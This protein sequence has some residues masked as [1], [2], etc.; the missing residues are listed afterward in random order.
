MNRKAL[1]KGLGALIP[2]A[3]PS[4]ATASAGQAPS[5]LPIERISSN[6]YQPRHQFDDAK[7]EELAQSIRSN[8]V[9]QPIVVRRSPDGDG[10]QL[11]AGERRFLAAKKAGRETIPAVVRAAS[12]REM[13]EFALVENVQREDLNPIDEAQAYHR[14]SLEFDFT[15][16]QM[17]ERVGK[18]RTTITNTLR[19]LNLSDPVQELI[20]GGRL[21]TGHAR[22]LLALE[23]AV[24]QEALAQE[25][26][27]R[28]LSVRQVEEMTAARRQRRPRNPA[29]RGRI[30]PLLASWEDELRHAFGTQVRIQGGT[31]RGR[32]EISYFSEEDLE[33]ILEVVGVISGGGGAAEILKEGV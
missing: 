22:C 15:H 5:E 17:A 23:S 1:G 33:R 31:A 16:E 2:E 29:R 26:L 9:I 4:P 19:L 32:I 11:I 6:P 14:M 3:P 24:E 13:L 27:K 25:I 28:G 18:D 20:A 7:L 8:G 30:H 21:S 12:R 10:Y